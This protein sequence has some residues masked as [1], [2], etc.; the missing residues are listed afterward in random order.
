MTHIDKRVPNKKQNNQS[1]LSQNNLCHKQS[2]Y[3][4]FQKPTWDTYTARGSY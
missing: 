4:E 1:S 3:P 2:R